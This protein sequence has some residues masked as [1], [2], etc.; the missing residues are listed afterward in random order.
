[1]SSKE[2]DK[3][4]DTFNTPENNADLVRNPQMGQQ[5]WIVKPG[6][7]TNRG[8]GINVCRDLS[9]IKGICANTNHNGKKRSYIIQ[10]YIERPLLY[11]Q[12]KFDIRCF[13]MTTTINNNLQ[14]YWYADGYLRTSC[15]E[16]STK[17]VTN[18]LVHLTNDAI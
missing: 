6:E 2:F 18:K 10:K 5:V 1:M 9:H 13:L 8:C 11:K 17:N 3:F 15:K 4:T 7:N 16:Y 14:A 12:R